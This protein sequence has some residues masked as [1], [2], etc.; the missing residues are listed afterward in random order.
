MNM[1]HHNQIVRFLKSLPNI[2]NKG[3]RQALIFSASLDKELEEQ[4]DF[5][6]T[7]ARFCQLLI[8]TLGRYGTL[9]DGR[10]ALVAIL[11]AAKN[12]VGQEGKEDCSELIQELQVSKACVS[13]ISLYQESVKP[14]A[15]LPCPVNAPEHTSVEFAAGKLFKIPDMILIPAGSFVMGANQYDETPQHTVEL[16]EYYISSYPIT[17]AHYS[18]FLKASGYQMPQNWDEKENPLLPV[19]GVSWY[20]CLEFCKWL[21]KITGYWFRLPTEAEWEKAA[22]GGDG[23]NWP[24]G[25][26]FDETRC[27]LACDLSIGGKTEVDNFS[28]IGNSPFG[29]SDMAGNVWE[30]T[31]SLYLPYPYKRDRRE[32]MDISGYR[33]MRGGSW[34]SSQKSVRCTYRKKVEPTVKRKDIGF[35]VV[36]SK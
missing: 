34:L 8:K 32:N 14:K 2:H 20:D 27:N 7:T 6:G 28:P 33:V 13:Q 25:N 18:K 1:E 35:R 30:W 17:N 9:K 5:E 10:H 31:N 12:N 19:T 23:R 15:I 3:D 21:C 11:E 24:W 36:Y 26:E 22:R 29:V 4:I 16:E